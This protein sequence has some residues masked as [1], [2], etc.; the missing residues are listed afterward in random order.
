MNV[1]AAPTPTVG[2]DVCASHKV[3]MRHIP[4]LDGV[5]AL[6][7]LGVLVFHTVPQLLPSGFTGVDVFYVLSGFLIAS[8]ILHDLRNEQF[9]MREF[10]LRRIQR[11]LPN[12]MVMA[13]FTAMAAIIFF[14]P[15]KAV[16][17]AQNALYALFDVSNFFILNHFGGYWGDSAASAPLLH[18]WSLAVEEQFY[19][20]FPMIL[21]LFARRVWRATLPVTLL[22]IGSFFLC[23]VARRNSAEFAFYM[24]PTRAWEPLI[25]AVFAAYMVPASHRQQLRKLSPRI[26][27]AGVGWIGVAA[28]LASF[29][30]VPETNFPGKWALLPTIGS[31]AV[32]ISIAA[33]HPF[34]PERF[35]AAK[36]V[37]L[38]GRLSYSIY[39][40]HWP[41]IIF[42]RQYSVM[43]GHSERY[44]AVIGAIVSLVVASAAYIGIEQPLRSRGPGRRARLITLAACFL[45]CVCACVALT[46]KKPIA[47]PYHL[48][49]QPSFS[50][51]TYSLV[52]WDRRAVASSAKYYDLAFS[53]DLPMS[54]EPWN[55]GG[56]IHEWGPGAPRVVVFGSSH[57]LMFAPIIDS[58]CQRLHLPVAFFIADAT[59]VFFPTHP[60]RRF[61]DQT[62]V[63]FDQARVKY[64]TQWHPDIL[65]VADRWDG[66]FDGTGQLAPQ[67][68]EFLQTVSPR[69]GH[70]ILTAQPPVLDLGDATNPREF[71][72]RYYRMHG[73]LPRIWPDSN[74]PLRHKSTQVFDSVSRAFGNVSV[75]RTDEPLY[76]SDRSI[77]YVDGRK[78]LYADAD[79]LTDD[80]AKLEQTIISQAIAT[81]AR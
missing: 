37:A 67:L 53:S 60:N 51:V 81:L 61:T 35:L 68:T 50:G 79:H 74:E 14:G 13:T 9:S 34:G 41:L 17:T 6:A 12:A 49:D 16:I 40:W 54:P 47:D 10:Y 52:G 77:R 80:G 1:G 62:A 24:L 57:G 43:R 15:F 59:P 72:T 23:I 70:V 8:V 66:R 20:F 58:V 73:S 2:E 29:F 36:P 32:L 39:L 42:G 56:L 11:L 30:V 7:I 28:I 55:E 21:L 71:V 27:F 18:T 63:S 3:S 26:E 45:T 48:F 33:P 5:R 76:N 65:I 46:L 31:L 75:L 44:G 4:A 38:I 78:F 22:A 19:M 64:L 69:V 25:G